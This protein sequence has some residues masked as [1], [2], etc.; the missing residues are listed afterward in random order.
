MSAVADPAPVA[1]RARAPPV[2]VKLDINSGARDRLDELGLTAVAQAVLNAIGTGVEPPRAPS[3]AFTASPTSSSSSDAG[4]VDTLATAAAPPPRPRRIAADVALRI[5]DTTG[6]VSEV[7]LV[8][9]EWSGTELKQMPRLDLGRLG[10]LAIREEPELNLSVRD[11]PEGAGDTSGA[12][13]MEVQ[14]DD[15]DDG[16]SARAR[17]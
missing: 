17:V 15:P 12:T 4:D 11:E 3:P 2:A 6:A 13:G 7:R 10:A 16:D 14:A 8:N 1:A 5:T 9:G